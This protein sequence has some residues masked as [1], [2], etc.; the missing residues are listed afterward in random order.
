M[1]LGRRWFTLIIAVVNWQTW[2]CFALAIWGGRS[3]ISALFRSRHVSNQ[4]GVSIPDIPLDEFAAR[5]STA[6]A[7]PAV[8]VHVADEV[9]TAISAVAQGGE[10]K[11]SAFADSTTGGLTV[12]L[13]DQGDHSYLVSEALYQNTI[14]SR[15]WGYLSVMTRNDSPVSRDLKMYAAGF[16]EGLATAQQIRDFR[17]NA[18]VLMQGEEDKHHGMENIENMFAKSVKEICAKSGVHPGSQLND[19]TVPNDAWWA[20]TRF[21]F[22]QLWGILDAYNTRALTVNYEAISMVDLL[23]LNSDGETPEL[24]MAYDNEEV[25]LRN[26]GD[27][28]TTVKNTS[29]IFLQEGRHLMQKLRKGKVA[30][31]NRTR[32]QRVTMASIRRKT[33]E[34]NLGESSWRTIK[35][36]SG[37]CSALVRLTEGNQD[38]MVGHTTFSDYGE[39]V[40]IFKYYDFALGADVFGKAGFSSYPGVAGST[41]DY[42]LLSSGLVVTETTISMLTDEPYDMLDDNKAKVPDFMRIMVSNR[43]AKNGADW[44][45]Y[46][47]KT[48]AGT[49]SSQWVIVDYNLF[50]PGSPVKTGTLTVLEQV[51][52][53]SRTADLSARLQERG[54]WASEN[55]A[56]FPEIRKSIGAADAEDLHGRLF[57]AEHN[58]RAN[59]FAATAPKVQTLADMRDE[60]RRNKWPHEVDGGET[61]T[62]D[63]A[64]AARGDLDKENP[65]ANGAVDSKVTNSCLAR[66]LQCDAI[67]GPT[68]DDQRPFRWTESGKELF[69]GVPH[70][71]LPN[72]WNFD[73]VRMTS[74][75][76][77]SMEA[78]C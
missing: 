39:M 38:L 36:S 62:P 17:H 76:Y 63:H 67:S 77:G 66:M 22:L 48:S 26:S 20:Q 72:V 19:D 53:M 23:I 51:P 11:L 31:G 50:N 18:Q 57:S 21:A 45:R 75:G 69:P 30:N 41:D 49:Y 12:K 71:G 47:T 46:M 14:S 59:I 60:M 6:S 9:K 2:H 3:D 5:F 78:T 7:P 1:V 29:T 32:E 34:T 42:Y 40:R 4:L 74:D 37:R 16:L 8:V 61:N 68:A 15:G 64:I 55:R 65:S 54:F 10:V 43:L 73:W 70:N 28:K 52:G 58:P 24:E 27:D 13:A 33:A 35:M 25:L 44:A 56:W